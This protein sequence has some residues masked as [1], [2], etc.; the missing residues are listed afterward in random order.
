[1][2]KTLLEDRERSIGIGLR[3][4]VE[5]RLTM[6]SDKVKYAQ[7]GLCSLSSPVLERDRHQ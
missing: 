3:D 4:K 5:I 6:C 2:L 1:M 7:Y